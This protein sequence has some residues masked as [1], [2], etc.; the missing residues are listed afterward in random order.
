MSSTQE[1]QKCSG[2]ESCSIFG[3]HVWFVCVLESALKGWDNRYLTNIWGVGLRT[4][5]KKSNNVCNADLWRAEPCLEIRSLQVLRSST[6]LP[7]V[8]RADWT[9]E[10]W[11]PPPCPGATGADDGEKSSPESSVNKWKSE[12]RT[13]HFKRLR[14]ET[15]HTHPVPIF[16]IPHTLVC[17]TWLCLH[18]GRLRFGQLEG[19]DP[20]L[21][22]H[23]TTGFQVI[24][25]RPT[26]GDDKVAG[27]IHS[28][29]RCGQIDC[30]PTCVAHLCLG[31][32]N[33]RNLLDFLEGKV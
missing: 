10:L 20:A 2:N 22:F 9:S 17:F 29:S 13:Q 25:L 23:L 30:A 19:S 8:L 18:T 21:T 16:T 28:D 1:R 24:R 12:N 27:V 5:E 14:G 4:K 33:Q 26:I 31:P 7:S 3:K 32:G 15:L 11:D 6:L